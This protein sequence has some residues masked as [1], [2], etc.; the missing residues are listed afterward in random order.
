MLMY[1]TRPARRAM[2]KR[3]KEKKGEGMKGEYNKEDSPHRF[4]C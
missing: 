2:V 4:I 1:M 3:K